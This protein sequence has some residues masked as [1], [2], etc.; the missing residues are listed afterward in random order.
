MA[1]FGISTKKPPEGPLAVFARN[2]AK[3]PRPKAKIDS[4]R[5]TRMYGA[6]GK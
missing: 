3:L 1:L 2:A 5:A 4:N 6:K